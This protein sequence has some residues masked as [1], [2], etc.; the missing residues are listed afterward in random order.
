MLICN[1]DR[2][3]HN[4]SVSLEYCIMH[5][6]VIQYNAEIAGKLTIAK[7]TESVIYT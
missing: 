5:L 1:Y 3:D 6:A 2:R 4:C 7:T